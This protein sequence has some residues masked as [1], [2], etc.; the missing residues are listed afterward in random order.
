MKRQ[1]INNQKALPGSGLKLT[2]L[3]LL[4]AVP[5][6][7]M[8]ASD[9]RAVQPLPAAGGGPAIGVTA[10]GTPVV[11]I[12]APNAAGLSHNKFTDYNVGAAGLVSTTA[13]RPYRRNSAA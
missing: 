13:A 2:A 11:N 5:A 3:F 10:N 1:K 9:T 12:V 6:V 8:Y 4:G 7:A